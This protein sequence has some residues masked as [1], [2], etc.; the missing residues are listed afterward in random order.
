MEK[1][2]QMKNVLFLGLLLFSSTLILAQSTNIPF[3]NNAYH[4]ADRLE[5]K[6]GNLAEFFTTYKPYQRKDVAKLALEYDK[7]T[8][9]D[10]KRDSLNVN[11]LYKDN[12]D[13]LEQ[14]EIQQGRK[15]LKKKFIDSTET[16]Y[17]YEL[18]KV[19]NESTNI[20]DVSSRKPIFKTFYKTPA[21]LFELNT[22]HFS[23]KLNPIIHFKVGKE[24]GTDGIIFLNTR[25]FDLRANI[26]DRV[27]IHTSL[28]E[29]QARFQQHITDGI[30]TPSDTIRAVPGAGFY[31]PYNSSLFNIDNGFDYL[32]AQ[33]YFAARISRHIHLQ[34]GHGKHFIGNGHRSMFLSDYSNNY[35]YLQ[36]NTRVWKI[37]YQNIFA[38]ITGQFNRTSFGDRTRPK[39]YLTAHHLS[40]NVTK[41][42]TIGVFESVVFDRGNTFELQ[43]LNPII[44]YRTVEQALGS[45]DNA[46]AGLDIKYNFFKRFSV[47]GQLVMDE[48]KFND[49]LKGN[50]CWCNKYGAQIGLKYIDVLGINQLDLQVEYNTARPFT[51]SHRDPTANYTHYNQPLAHPLGAN[52]KEI[53]AIV[54]YQPIP[55]LFLEGRVVYATYGT[56]LPGDNW[57]QNIYISNEERSLPDGIDSEF[58]HKTGQGTSNQ[59]LIGSLTASYQLRHNLSIDLNY[60]LRNL[61]SEI[62]TED[63]SRNFVGMGIRLNIADKLMDYE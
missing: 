48:F 57:G 18:D 41:N 20:P 36:L 23:F 9:L 60:I 4:L 61:N 34:F 6:S 46:I 2:F 26:D 17:T 11:W 56:D 63:Y 27:F 24:S 1:S 22:P 62:D 58:G 19:E 50:G 30:L 51:Y 43:Y 54:K 44:L 3:G 35:F 12:N 25:G 13:W 33:G 55:N 59:L 16:F 7:Q 14:V 52:F 42:L 39:K 37:N 15:F 40:I 28:F 32:N 5:I 21:H 10:R 49:L 38:E 45:P 8:A 29:N 53:L 31:K 47:Y